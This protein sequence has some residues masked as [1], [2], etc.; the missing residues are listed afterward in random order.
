MW[1][2][3]HTHHF[4][5]ILIIYIAANTTPWEECW[6]K[7]LRLPIHEYY[8]Y[9]NLYEEAKHLVRIFCSDAR[10]GDVKSLE[11]EIKDAQYFVAEQFVLDPESREW[12]RIDIVLA[13]AEAGLANDGN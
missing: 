11:I 13:G 6:E 1:S 5:H 4:Y 10:S 8:N 3:T 2:G 9:H 12:Q 7:I